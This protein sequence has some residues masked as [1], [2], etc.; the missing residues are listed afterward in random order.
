VAALRR[1]GRA[2]VYPFALAL[3]ALPIA[4]YHV[5]LERFPSLETG[6]CAVDNP[7]SIIWV[8]HFGVYTIP[9]M[10]ASGFVAIAVLTLIAG[11]HPQGV[12]T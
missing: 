10:A 3:G 5:V 8:E 6:A 12:R 7:C 2:W 1:D 4:T 11:R 9:F